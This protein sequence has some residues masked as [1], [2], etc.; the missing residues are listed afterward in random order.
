MAR[1][2]PVTRLGIENAYGIWPSA[3]NAAVIICA[4]AVVYL[5]VRLV[6]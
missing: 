1:L 2:D 5:I 4:C 6:T 3:F